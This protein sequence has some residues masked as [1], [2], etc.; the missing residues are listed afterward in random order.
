MIVLSRT[1]LQPDDS[2]SRSLRCVLSLMQIFAGKSGP[3]PHFVVELCDIDNAHLITLVAP[4][5]HTTY[6][7]NLEQEG[8][9]KEQEGKEKI[10][11]RSRLTATSLRNGYN[12]LPSCW[13]GLFSPFF[14][15]II[16]VILTIYHHLFFL[17][18]FLSSCFHSFFFLSV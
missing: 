4:V 3:V 6:L 11:K 9:E 16:I 7:L 13:F 15:V 8:K 18:F 14:F 1:E 17:S 10:N 12:I 2:D 5:R